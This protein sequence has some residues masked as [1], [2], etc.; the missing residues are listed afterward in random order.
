MDYGHRLK[1]VFFFTDA[2]VS[3]TPKELCQ[4][5]DQQQ[6]PAAAAG[7]V[8]K[9]KDS[10][11]GHAKDSNNNVKPVN[12]STT[13]RK[14][15]VIKPAA[16][17]E[18][19]NKTEESPLSNMGGAA[20][21][22]STPSEA[23]ATASD[24]AELTKPEN[25]PPPPSAALKS[26]SNAVPTSSSSSSAGGGSVLSVLSYAQVAQRE[27]DLGCQGGGVEKDNKN[28][29]SSTTDSSKKKEASA[30]QKAP[31]TG[32]NC[33]VFSR[34]DRVIIGNGIVSGHSG[35]GV[36]ASTVHNNKKERQ[37]SGGTGRDRKESENSGSGNKSKRG[38]NKSTK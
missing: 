4:S 32:E 22:A 31:A 38:I 10:E 24:V 20:A 5:N 33:S 19:A 28:T 30:T 36:A 13:T 6:P 16:T 29:P 25:E 9:S 37:N 11:T 26:P 2:S 14:H 35:R 1:L 18:K 3:S 23:L 7:A 34:V 12:K 15:P 21:V 17:A 8:A 27:N